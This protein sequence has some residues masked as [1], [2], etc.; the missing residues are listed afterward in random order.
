M[1]LKTHRLLIVG[2][3]MAIPTS[4]TFLRNRRLGVWDD[5]AA[6]TNNAV[7]SDVWSTLPEERSADV[8][9]TPA[10]ASALNTEDV[11]SS[12]LW[13][14][15]ATHDNDANTN[16]DAIP[17]I[18]STHRLTEAS[19][20][21]ISS[22]ADVLSSPA[23]DSGGT[24]TCG[25]RIAWLKSSRGGG[26]SDTDAKGQVATEFPVVCGSCATTTCSDVLSTPA[27]GP[28]GSLTPAEEELRGCEI[29]WATLKPTRKTL[30]LARYRSRAVCAKPM[31]T[32]ARVKVYQLPHQRPRPRGPLTILLATLLPHLPHHHQRKRPLY[33]PRRLRRL[34]SRLQ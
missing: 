33:L 19:S 25:E 30:L 9:G 24:H 11:W 4:A 10:P 28:K 1:R 5:A 20:M 23:T 14:D 31:A 29:T 21:S 2:S 7:P 8:W 26:L 15:K 6:S 34:Q 3:C 27:P 12:L 32:Y 13:S 18:W 17:D 22:C 16:S